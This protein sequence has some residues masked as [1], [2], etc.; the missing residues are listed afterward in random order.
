MRLSNFFS[1]SC[2]SSFGWL[3]QPAIKATAM[4]T[5]A[6]AAPARPPVLFFPGIIDSLL[7][8]TGPG[9]QGMKRTALRPSDTPS[10]AELLV[11]AVR[12]RD[13]ELLG[14]DVEL[15]RGLVDRSVR[16]G[17]HR[18]VQVDRILRAVGEG[19]DLDAGEEI[20]RGIQR[21][22]QRVA[23]LQ[24]ILDDDHDGAL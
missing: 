16:E 12:D 17:S 10:A 4:T 19:G 21:Q 20:R 7:S 11:A 3:A 9:P 1:V 2:A 14:G 13:A 15:D 22:R 23:G 5:A 8:L 18:D 6:S 24:V